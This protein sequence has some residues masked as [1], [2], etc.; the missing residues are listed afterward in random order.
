MTDLMSNT[1][2]N[3]PDELIQRVV[4]AARAL[5]I[6]PHAFMVDAIRQA[7]RGVERRATFIAQARDARAEMLKE[8]QGYEVN[9][10]QDY[11]RNRI[12]HTGV[13]RPTRKSWRK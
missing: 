11:L 5:G 1:S 4:H 2:L 8:Q 12:E 3:L 13:T 6:S 7:T 9:E 10:V